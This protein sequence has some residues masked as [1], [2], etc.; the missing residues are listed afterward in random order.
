MLV[1]QRSHPIA[2]MLGAAALWLT[3][4][5]WAQPVPVPEV[6]NYQGL[7][8]L[9]SG[10]SEVNGSFTLR[11]QLFDAARGGAPLWG[12]ALDDVQVVHGQF[13]V[14]LGNGWPLD[15]VPH[16]ALTEVFKRSHVY[17]EVGIGAEEPIRVRQRFVAAPYAFAAQHAESAVHGVPAG[18]VVPF[19]G[20]A[21]PY[22]W[23]PCDGAARSKTQYPALYAALRDNGVCIWGEDG[24]HFNLPNLGGRAVAGATGTYGPGTRRGAEKHALTVAELPSHTHEYYDKHWNGDTQ[25]IG[26]DR[27]A[28]ANNSLGSTARTTGTTGGGE[29]HNEIQPSAVVNFIIKY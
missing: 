14:V 15:G 18:T 28:V 9:E 25:G 29:A 3:C 2:Y 20:G 12:E 17:I 27:R 11:F 8:Y 13:N 4:A 1:K 5:S 16:G 6:V 7:V 22:G 24:G 19:A 10:S 23:L 26:A 21:V